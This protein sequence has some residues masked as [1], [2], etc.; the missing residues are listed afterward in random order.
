MDKRKY[1]MFTMIIIGVLSILEW[2]ISFSPI[3]L[4]ASMFLIYI[5]YIIKDLSM[6]HKSLKKIYYIYKVMIIIFIAAFILVEGMII[7]NINEGE[8]ITNIDNID[9]MIVLGAKLDG[10]KLSNTLKLRLDKTIEYYNKHKDINIIV[11]GGKTNSSDISEALAMENYLI[12]NGVNK[13]NIIKED[14][15]T[16]TLENII[17]SKK[18]LEDINYNGKVLIVTSD[19]HLFRGRLIASILGIENKG[20]C[21][22]SELSKRIYYMIKEYPASI[23]DLLRSTV[24]RYTHIS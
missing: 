11:S 13:N 18:I 2:G 17:Y 19:F 15:A 12:A 24:Y 8:N 14:K 16:S 21:S 9:T 10:T 5:T 4:I 22:K 1:T 3:F 6:K 23:R 20:I 7:F